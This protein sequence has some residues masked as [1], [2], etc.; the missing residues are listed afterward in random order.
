MPVAGGQNLGHIGHLVQIADMVGVVREGRP[1]AVSADKGCEA[2]KVTLAI[3]ESARSG[4]KI[5]LPGWNRNEPG[6][7]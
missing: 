6:A 2:R 3:S 4:R 7:W 1:P 5:K